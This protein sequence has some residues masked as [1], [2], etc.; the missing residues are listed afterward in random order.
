MTINRRRQASLLVAL[1][2]AFVVLLLLACSL[3]SPSEALQAGQDAATAAAALQ[4]TA[5]VLAPT[6]EAS[7]IRQTVEALGP[8]IEAS[9]I[10]QTIEAYAPTLQAQAPELRQTLEA[11]ATNPPVDGVDARQTLVALTNGSGTASIDLP[12]PSE[13]QVLTSESNRLT[14]TTPQGYGALTEFY[15]GEMTRRGWQRDNSASATTS[16]AATLIFTK[17]NQTATIVIARLAEGTIVDLLI[18]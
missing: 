3:P 8:T 11:F 14:I 5:D 18:S 16:Q 13:Y 10:R 7:G 1:S 2:S 6:F 17:G 9:G 4:Q 12:L 15:E